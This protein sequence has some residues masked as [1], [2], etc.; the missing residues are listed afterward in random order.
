MS[1]P[2]TVN[3]NIQRTL[4]AIIISMVLTIAYLTT[5]VS[6][7]PAVLPPIFTGSEKMVSDD[8]PS[9]GG[10]IQYTIVVSNAG[11]FEEFVYV[12]D[13]LPAEL[14][15][16]T[17]S[18]TLM[19]GDVDTELITWTANTVSWH[20]A[21]IG[22][23]QLTIHYD[24]IVSDT[25][26]TGDAFTN[27]VVIT[28]GGQTVTRTATATVSEATDLYLPILFTPFSVPSFT[29]EPRPNADNEWTLT[30]DAM[31]GVSYVIEEDM[32]PNFT[33]PDEYTVNGSSRTFQHA[34]TWNNEYYYRVKAVSNGQTSDWS[35]TVHVIAGYRDDFNN[36]LSGWSTRRTTNIDKANSFYE[37][38]QS[39]YVMSIQDKWDWALA[40]PLR[41]APAPPYEIEYRM[42]RVSNGNLISGG[43]VLG[44]DWNGEPCPDL[45][46]VEGWYQH[47]NCFN[48]MYIQNMINLNRDRNDKFNV[49]FEVIDDL[50]WCL[51]CGGSPMKRLG[52][53]DTNL[54][55]NAKS[56]GWNVHTVRVRDSG[57]EFFNN[58]E[59]YYTINDT[60]YINNPYFGVFAST[61]EYNN[62]AWRVDYFQVKALND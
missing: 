56:D 38:D 32:N 31:T 54:L 10:R 26:S 37:E 18:I 9:P 20:G 44:G 21:I 4:L 43:M 30:W 61:D 7:A 13:T 35:E 28:G 48:N 2:L 19:D 15:L 6:A 23:E 42:I 34:L 49:Q 53:I 24:A 17:S 46:S 58:G 59:Y 11:D 41:K 45:S 1:K 57:I 39:W 12:T 47:T 50:V 5:I 8:T 14:S 16:I 36:D 22:N 3:N 52:T 60:D 40:S 33:S 62:S 51:E 55:E 25:L 29:S 27:T